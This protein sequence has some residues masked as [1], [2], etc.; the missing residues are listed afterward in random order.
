MTSFE[1]LT[2]AVNPLKIGEWIQFSAAG[3]FIVQSRHFTLDLLRS[4][5]LLKAVHHIV[6]FRRDFLPHLIFICRSIPS[7]GD[8]V[9]IDRIQKGWICYLAQSSSSECPMRTRL[10][11][12]VPRD[13]CNRDRRPPYDHNPRKIIGGQ[14]SSHNPG[15]GNHRPACTTPGVENHS[16]L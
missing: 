4:L 15:I 5:S 13:Y 7:Q 2:Q 11:L 8:R 3:T 14:I 16:P 6:E 9:V 12:R 10:I 1:E